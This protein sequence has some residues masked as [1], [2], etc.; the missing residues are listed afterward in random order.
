M[1]PTA[2]SLCEVPAMT[3]KRFVKLLMGRGYSRNYA[4][5]AALLAARG[6]HTFDGM[7]FAIRVIDGDPEVMAVIKAVCDKIAAIAGIP[8]S[9]LYAATE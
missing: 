5:Q 2:F 3:R 4:N 6:G 8:R 9:I 1:W 7:Y